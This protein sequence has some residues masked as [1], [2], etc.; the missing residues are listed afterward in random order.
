VVNGDQVTANVGGNL[1]I[2]SL[3]DTSQ[4]NERSKSAGGSVTFGP[5]PGASLNIGQTKINS[6]FKSV[7]EQSAIRAGDGGFN[8]SVQGATT[9]TGGQITS[10]QAA[11]DA[12]KNTYSSA[13][14][15]T[16]TDLQN[17]ATF[18]ANSVG[19]GLGTGRPAPGQSLSAGLSGVGIG[20]DTGSASSTTTAGIS[21]VAG[22]TQARTGDKSTSIAPIFNKDEVR[23]EVNAQVAITSEF[24]KQASRAVGDYAKTQ[25]DKALA[26]D[27]KAGMD[28]WREGG[29]SRVALHAV[30]GGLTGGAAGAVGAGAASAAAPSIEELQGKLQDTLKTAGLGDSAAKTIASLAGGTTAAAIGAAASGGSTA[31]AATAF[32]AD[33]NNRQ[34]HPSEVTRAKDL[35]AK[36]GGK[37]KQSEIEEQMRLMGNAA[38]GE[39][40]NTTTVLTTTA[41]VQKSYSDDPSMPRTAQG[42]V[43]LEVPGQ[44][45]PE[46]QA[47]IINNTKEGAGFIPG[48]SPYSASNSGLNR[49]TTTNTPSTASVTSACANND[50][51][52]RSGVGAQQSTMPQMTQAARQAISD[53]AETTSR[54]AG[55]IGAAAT[56]ATAAASPPVK[57]ITGAVAVGATVIGVA[58]DA[59]A[60]MANPEPSKFIKEQIGI[61]MPAS[62]LVERYPLW[63]PIINEVAEQLKKEAPK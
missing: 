54:Q 2:Q 58:A 39:L 19:V 18:S 20:S 43:V 50:L 6:D 42:P 47:W 53:G 15:T 1:T 38:T 31:G 59:V 24:G 61:G 16:T 9:L 22:D 45:N 33:M 35:A 56:A 11:V 17:S 37:Y 10:S 34:L 40:P 60:Y 49:P 55:V 12:G 62:V 44:A 63:A 57:P 27:D 29:T 41:A 25:Y 26:S 32:N 48:A 8:V 52:C 51:A 36:S 23:S 5:A 46:L 30:V 4:Y 14:G 7:G 13:G 28:A 21:G 3:Q